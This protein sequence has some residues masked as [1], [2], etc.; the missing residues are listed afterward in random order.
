[1]TF[2][3]C[4]GSAS[5]LIPELVHLTILLRIL[6]SCTSASPGPSVSCVIL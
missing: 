4:L 3:A 6:T 2:S 1:M 5:I